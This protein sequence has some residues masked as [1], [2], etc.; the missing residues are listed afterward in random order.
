MK[1]TLKMNHALTTPITLL[2]MLSACS[3]TLRMELS[4][5]GVKNPQNHELTI[6]PCESYD[7]KKFEQYFEE[8]NWNCVRH[9]VVLGAEMNHEFSDGESFLSKM[10]AHQS[11]NPELLE[12]VLGDSRL[13]VNQE[14]K[15]SP[16]QVAVEQHDL[17]TAKK[18]AERGVNLNLT[19]KVA[20]WM[21]NYSIGKSDSW[22][23]DFLLSKG[24]N[25]NTVDESG[26]T[27]LIFALMREDYKS[28]DKLITLMDPA[29]LSFVS[30]KSG[31]ALELAFKSGN[32]DLAQKIM[33]QGVLAEN[34]FSRLSLYEQKNIHELKDLV[35]KGA[36]IHQKTYQGLYPIHLAVLSKN[37]DAMKVL[38]DAG[39][40]LNVTDA[41]GNGLLH[42]AAY[43]NQVKMVDLMVASLP[44]DVRNNAGETP[45]LR[46]T[47][48]DVAKILIDKG[49][50][51]NA[52]TSQ[53]KHLI[54]HV[55]D[56]RLIQ[57]DLPF[58]R[59]L[60]EQ[61]M[62]LN[63]DAKFNVNLVSHLLF[64][65]HSY[66]DDGLSKLSDDQFEMLKLM[67]EKGADLCVMDVFGRLPIHYAY[68]PRVLEYFV[69]LNPS[70]LED[71]N[72][73]GKTLKQQVEAMKADFEKTSQLIKGKDDDSSVF[74]QK[75]IETLTALL[76]II[77]QR[78]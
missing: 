4:K 56:S 10:I 71:Q 39:A 2:L 52:E 63:A 26:M 19:D 14:S 49:A 74:Y 23:F 29:H 8:L 47:S 75:V 64:D 40:K 77:D 51:I 9:G 28:A 6:G 31:S 1:P 48:K 42:T 60:I 32:S 70:L 46:T 16:F 65:L 76:K 57:S 78:K 35:A 34:V 38:M 50:K 68:D 44:V 41:D 66:G 7:A 43:L 20:S 18:L 69:N 53:G 72:S 73:K 58:V 12:F 55:L 30:E 27:P 5:S 15:T 24:V 45:L 17:D 62:D 54:S 13:N 22:L 3:P 59:Y 33:A 21:L 37:L 25:P 36:D 61:G 11:E 67:I